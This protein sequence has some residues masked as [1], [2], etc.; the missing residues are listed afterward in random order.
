MHGRDCSGIESKLLGCGLTIEQTYLMATAKKIG[1]HFFDIFTDIYYL[2]TVPFYSKILYVLSIIALLLPL[3]PLYWENI[4]YEKNKFKK[5][6]HYFTGYC[7]VHR[8]YY[9]QDEEPTTDDQKK[10]YIKNDLASQI[11]A[12]L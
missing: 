6:I 12:E 10:E 4:R 7:A 9:D 5:L 2:L 1:W 11:F 3:L 8:Y